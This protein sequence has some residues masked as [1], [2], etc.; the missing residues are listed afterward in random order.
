MVGEGGCAIVLDEPAPADDIRADPD[1]RRI[2]YAPHPCEADTLQ[3]YGRTNSVLLSDIL[4][5]LA[6]RYLHCPDYFCKSCGHAYEARWLGANPGLFGCLLAI[7]IS[8]PAGV[9]VGITTS[10]IAAGLL[11]GWLALLPSYLLIYQTASVYIRLRYRQRAR[12]FRKYGCP[13][14]GSRR[15]VRP[16]GAF[17]ALPCPKCKKR[18]M[19]IKLVGWS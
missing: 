4:V 5:S 10:S 3:E 18:T 1:D 15:A 6:G 11:W 16:N 7:C 9:S 13:N 14:C 17:R 8:I 2:V 19:K 12:E